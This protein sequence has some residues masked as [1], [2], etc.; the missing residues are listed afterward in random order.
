Q[1]P[2]T[3]YLLAYYGRVKDERRSLKLFLA[4]VCSNKHHWSEAPPPMLTRE[5]V[6]AVTESR[7]LVNPYS[8]CTPMHG[9]DESL[10]QHAWVRGVG[11]HHFSVP[12]ELNES[13][14]AYGK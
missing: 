1:L 10:I 12:G 9:A 6:N 11:D 14:A 8:D 3:L 2:G 5:Q 7:T 13:I 4:L